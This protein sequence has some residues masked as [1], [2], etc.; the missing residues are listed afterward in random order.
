MKKI[1]LTAMAL[2][3]GLFANAQL[4]DGFEDYPLGPYFGGHWTN[5]SMIDN[6]ENIRVSD[7][8]ASEGTQSGFIGGDGLQDAILNVGMKTSGKWVYS[9]DMF[10]D[11]GS[12]GYFNAQHDLTKLGQSG[13]WA[14]EVYVGTT[15]DGD[16]DPGKIYFVVGQNIFSFD[17][18]EEEWFN[19]AIQ[20]DLA[21]NKVKIYKDGDELTFSQ[22]IP[23]GTNPNFQGK[24]NGFD[25]YSASSTNYMFIDNINF[26]EGE[27]GV[28]DLSVSAISIYPT[29]V[30][31]VLNVNAKSAISNI[32]VFNVAGQ[33]VMK[34][35]P[36]ANSAQLNTSSLSKGVYMIKVQT[37]KETLTK[38]FVVK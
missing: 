31:D 38:K 8:V 9:M 4:T 33:Q 35:N 21:T 17:Y 30:K 15:Q 1:Y 3:F 36:N 14:Y 5:W 13:N 27:L 10:I 11:F 24:L 19:V 26:Y 29:V 25:F 28:N 32:A 7:D 22:E 34:L 37:G 20:Q 23:F 6:E 16:L 18:T 2:S 12:S